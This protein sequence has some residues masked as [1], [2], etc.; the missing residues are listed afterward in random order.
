MTDAVADSAELLVR[1]DGHVRILQLNRPM[2]RNALSVSLA[3]SLAQAALDAD[4]DR[5][6]RAIVL[7]GAGSAFCAGADLKE[8]QEN[9]ASGQTYRAPAQC[10]ERQVF[11]VVFELSKPTLAALN[12]SAVAGGCELALACDLRIGHADIQIGLPEARVGMGAN[13]GSVLLPRLIPRAIA[14]ELMLTGAYIDG[15]R[16]LEL[17]LLN[18][19]VEPQAVLAETVALAHT[20]AGNAPLSV[21]RIKAMAV[22]TAEMPV[23]AALRMEPGPSPFS[24]EDRIEGIKARLEKRPPVWKG[25]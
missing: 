25:R 22:R 18:R 20:I 10:P 13:F 21:R 14:L 15:R 23:A 19:L 12:G 6:V 17:G 7:T 16:A 2:R 8:M 24:S 3:R 1:D 11:D 4:S 9:D 5:S